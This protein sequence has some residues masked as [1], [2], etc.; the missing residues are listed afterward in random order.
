MNTVSTS[1]GGGGIGKP[2]ICGV[3]GGPAAHHAAAG[4]PLGWLLSADSG[5]GGS[6]SGHQTFSAPCAEEEFIQSLI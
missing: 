4:A 6:F 3:L 2:T 5:E 1:G